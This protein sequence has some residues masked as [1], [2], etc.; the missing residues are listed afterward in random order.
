ML[1]RFFGNSGL[2]VPVLG[3]GAMQ[4]GDVR[5]GEREVGG[6]NAANVD[7]NVAAVG[8]GALATEQTAALRK[9]YEV[10]GRDWRGLV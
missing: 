8:R 10:H 3:F 9:A 1:R 7:R 4:I 6:V 5:L 2:Q